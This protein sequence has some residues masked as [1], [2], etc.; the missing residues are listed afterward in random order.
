MTDCCKK[1]I[2]NEEDKKTLINRLK[3]IEGQVRGISNMVNDDRYCEDIIIQLSAVNSSIKSLANLLLQKHMKSC[4]KDRLNN[5]DDTILD[6]I[7]ELFK[8]LQ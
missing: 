5:G 3:R 8:K 4:V 1:T 2:R 7:V 6:E